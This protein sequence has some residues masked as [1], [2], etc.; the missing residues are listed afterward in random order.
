MQRYCQNI[1]G[2]FRLSF[3]SRANVVKVTHLNVT[4]SEASISWAS[5]I[6]ANVP[7]RFRWHNVRSRSTMIH[8]RFTRLSKCQ[9]STV[10]DMDC[11]DSFGGY[12]RT[13]GVGCTKCD[14][15]SV[16]VKNIL[17]KTIA[18]RSAVQHCVPC[19]DGAKICNA[20]DIEM[21]LGFSV[22]KSC[23]AKELRTVFCLNLMPIW[24]LQA[25]FV[26]CSQ[27]LWGM[28]VGQN[29]SRGFHCPNPLACPGANISVNTNTSPCEKG[30]RGN[31]WKHF[32][33]LS[34][35]QLRFKA[36]PLVPGYEGVGCAK[37]TNDHARSNSNVFVCLRCASW[38]YAVKNM[39][40]NM[41]V[42]HR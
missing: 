38:P 2:H 10:H 24:T 26:P 40:I 37:C 25:N 12:N 20:T 33:Q 22:R 14:P 17:E 7:W 30:L 19:P 4:G 8:L 1:H 18:N 23:G 36:P 34:D 5:G 28:M 15:G 16:F 13:D 3:P 6:S 31:M 42:L 27:W 35:I 21:Q 9:E 11:D 41:V 32:F 29:I 39:L